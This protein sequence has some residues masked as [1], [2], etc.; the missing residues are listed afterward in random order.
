[1]VI[2]I[3][4]V[5]LGRTMVAVKNFQDRQGIR[6][7]VST[8]IEKLRQVQMEASAV[9]IPRECTSSLLGYRVIGLENQMRIVPDCES[10]IEAVYV[11]K[12]A[13]FCNP[14]DFTFL[15]PAGNLP[16]TYK[17]GVCHGN[18]VLTFEIALTGS[19]TEAIKYRI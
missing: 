18:M 15:T 11:M 6:Q 10:A 17:I 3:I 12:E 9:E 2:S 7:E 13:E 1:M 4:L 5:L 14:V 19:I 8:V 16:D